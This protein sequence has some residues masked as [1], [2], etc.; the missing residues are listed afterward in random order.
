MPSFRLQLAAV[1]SLAAASLPAVAQPAHAPE[2]S[3]AMDAAWIRAFAVPEIDRPIDPEA[4]HPLGEEN[5][6]NTDPRFAALLKSALPQRQW[7]WY[8][9]RHLVSTA[10]LIHTFVGVPGDAILDQNRYV[11]LDGCVPHYCP[12]HGM[13]WID[14]GAHPA[15]LIFAGTGEVFSDNSADKNRLWIFSSIKLNWQ[16]IPQPFLASLFRWLTLIAIPGGGTSGYKYNFVLVT[17]VQP[18]GV[19]EDI[20]PETLHLRSIESGAK[21]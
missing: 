20:T 2:S 6:I 8:E 19:M 4:A 5:R 10:N 1:L 12:D 9:H 7:F 14:T 11:T 3:P 13:L 18:N 16:Q 15:T 21:Q 17:I